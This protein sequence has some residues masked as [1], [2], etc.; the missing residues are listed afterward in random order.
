MHS[1]YFLYISFTMIFSMNDIQF[2][3]VVC[4]YFTVFYRPVLGHGSQ[5]QNPKFWDGQNSDQ[6]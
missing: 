4:V 1:Q 3:T 2:T 6:R 5:S